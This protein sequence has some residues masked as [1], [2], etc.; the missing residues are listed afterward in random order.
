MTSLTNQKRL[1]PVLTLRDGA[2]MKSRKFRDWRY[3]GDVLNAV[4]I[5]NEMQVD[6]IVILDTQASNEN[7]TPN[8]DLIEKIASECSLPIAYGGGLITVDDAE[9]VIQCGVDKVIINSAFQRN[10]RIITDI[11]SRIGSSSTVVSLD[12]KFLMDSYMVG[13]NSLQDLDAAVIRANNVGA[14][15]LLVQSVERDGT[16]SSPDLNL[17]RSVVLNSAIPVVYAGGVSSLYHVNELW[18][19]G[20]DGVGAGAWFVFNG[21]LEAVLISYP[22]LPAK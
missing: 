2:L 18:D 15:E 12:A 13:R 1:I 20:V 14:G 9:R 22:L 10:P 8:F 21:P 11:A 16:Q 6:E 4:K 3:I 19:T 17:A 7:R 5:F